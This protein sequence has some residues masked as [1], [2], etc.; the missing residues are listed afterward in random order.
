MDNIIIYNTEDGQTNVRLYAKDG[1]VWMTQSQMAELFQCT[2]SNV[3]LHLQAIYREGSLQNRQPVRIS[4]RFKKT[5]LVKCNERFI[6]RKT[7][8]GGSLWNIPF[9]TVTKMTLS[10]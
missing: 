8:K 3:N 10:A 9:P 6:F 5:V 1:T 7:R 2:R 4:Y